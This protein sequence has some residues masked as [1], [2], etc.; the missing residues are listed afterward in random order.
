MMRDACGDEACADGAFCLSHPSKGM[1]QSGGAPEALEIKL[2][3]LL[4]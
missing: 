2:C 3:K 4:A 1:F